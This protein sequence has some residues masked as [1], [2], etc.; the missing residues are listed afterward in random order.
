[1]H[2]QKYLEAN[3]EEERMTVKSRKIEKAELLQKTES[4]L[5]SLENF[6]AKECARKIEEILEYHLEDSIE[7]ALEDIKEQL[8]LYED[9]AAEQMLRELIEQIG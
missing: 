3:R 4:A 7:A 1:M 2:I 8:K 6:E 5:D 9:E